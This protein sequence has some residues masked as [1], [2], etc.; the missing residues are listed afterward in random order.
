[1][2]PIRT[3]AEITV[4]IIIQPLERIPLYQ[5]ISKK[6]AELHFLGMPCKD[7]AKSLNISKGTVTKAYK[8][9]KTTQEGRKLKR[10]IVG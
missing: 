10:N 8:F 6:V 3:A 1:M 7:I 9:H 4:K 2:Q 5:K